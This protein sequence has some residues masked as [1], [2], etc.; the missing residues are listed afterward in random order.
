MFAR[1]A[2]RGLLA[3]E[4]I[5]ACCEWAQSNEIT[6]GTRSLFPARPYKRLEV[7]PINMDDVPPKG[8]PPLAHFA[9]VVPRP[10]IDLVVTGGVLAALK[11]RGASA[12]ANV[13][14]KAVQYY[15]D[16]ATGAQATDP[17][18]Q[19]RVSVDAQKCDGCHF[20]LEFHGGNRN[21]NV[22][23]CVICHNP[24]AVLDGTSTFNFKDMVHYIHTGENMD[25]TFAAA[26]FGG[27]FAEMRY[28]RD[29]KDCL[30][31]YVAKTPIAYGIPLP[32][33]AI[34]TDLDNV[35]TV[36]NPTASACVTCH[37]DTTF[38][39]PHVANQTAGTT[40]FCASCHTTGLLVGPD[41]AHQPVR[42]FPTD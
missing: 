16:V 39:A 30:A 29:R 11:S 3:D 21:E 17:A 32:A 24:R 26:Y 20:R 6:G 7:V 42:A 22:Q 4:C 10:G 18:K 12:T 5:P 34:G 19:R 37:T 33:G 31:C 36:R 40:E 13:G 8:P 14:G 9:L 28:P 15:F 1:P 38:T 41:F 23:Q 35:G 25:P 2:T 27:R